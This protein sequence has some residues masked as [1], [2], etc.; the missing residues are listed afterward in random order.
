MASQCVSLQTHQSHDNYIDVLQGKQLKRTIIN[1]IREFEVCKEDMNKQ[2]NEL[3][4]DS[5]KYLNQVQESTIIQLN[6]MKVVQNEKTEFS[7]R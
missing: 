2:L 7:E 6:E 3:K 5:N 4:K 1:F